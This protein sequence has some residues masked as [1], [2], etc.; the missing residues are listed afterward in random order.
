M[1]GFLE[2]MLRLAA[3]VGLRGASLI[4]K[5]G[6]M[7]YITRYIGL[8][9]VGIFGLLQAANVIGTKIIGG[10][11]Y[12]VAN[13]EMV[14][15]PPLRQATI[16]RDQQAA[17]IVG[18]GVV[19]I[20][21]FLLWPFIPE[22]YRHYT[23]YSVI[24]LIT[25][26]QVLELGNILIAQHRQIHANVIIGITNGLWAFVLIPIG[27]LD[28]TWRTLD[29]VILGWLLGTLVSFLL[30][31]WFL[32]KLPFPRIAA[33][34][35][36]WAWVRQALMRGLP[37]YIAGLAQNGSIYVDRYVVGWLTGLELAGVFVMFW[38]FA[39]AVQVLVQTGL[40]YSEFPRLIADYKTGDE[41]G[42]WRRFRGMSLRMALAGAG[43]CLLAAL[44]IAPVIDYVNRP[45]ASE[46]IGIFGLMLLGFWIKFQ[47]DVSQYTLY[48]RHQDRMLTLA[49]VLNLV[50]ASVSNLLLVWSFGIYGAAWSLI[51]TAL[52][53]TIL[54]GAMLWR[55]RHQR[56]AP[57]DI[58]V[59]ELRT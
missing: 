43:A 52:F 51:V 19:I 29:H 34:R 31:L 22:S 40:L 44:L 25:G 58:D 24:L 20:L 56:A 17:Y 37:L 21:A 5:F 54:Q 27:L 47:A 7:I 18:Y 3:N 45:L 36:N 49:F 26:H 35:P 12:F 38:S 8:E 23:L 10:G 16:I 33:Q 32:A 59:P 41:A 11:L 55:Q 50:V 39:Y 6:L 57:A 2:K 42:F 30:A 48:A 4:A 28:P 53:Q 46:Y 9:A 14:D 13:R 15:T 1:T